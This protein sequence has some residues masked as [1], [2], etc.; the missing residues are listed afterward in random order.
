MS[1]A[2]RGAHS[3]GNLGTNIGAVA[4]TYAY[5]PHHI[6]VAPAVSKAFASVSHT[7]PAASHLAAQGLTSAVH[8]IAPLFH[9]A[10][11]FVTAHVG[12]ATLALAA[13]ALPLIGILALGVIAIQLFRQPGGFPKLL[14][15]AIA[16]C[17]YAALTGGIA[18]WPMG[19]IGAGTVGK[20]AGWLL[21]R[22][23]G[24]LLDR[25]IPKRE[26]ARPAMAA[27]A[28]APPPPGAV[29]APA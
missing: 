27:R 16:G 28:M 19:I 13:Q 24:W 29:G 9:T 6:T 3:L 26:A 23:G 21:G 11:T 17:A 25:R 1:Y 15:L 10:A 5:L 14:S 18:L 12:A 7:F 22:A 2:A 4:G 20:T 8:W